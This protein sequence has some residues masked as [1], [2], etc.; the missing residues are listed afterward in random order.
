MNYFL[1]ADNKFVWVLTQ[2]PNQVYCIDL[3][4]PANTKKYPLNFTPGKMVL[5]PANQKLYILN[6]FAYTMGAT[7]LDKIYVM[8]PADG[9]IERTITV[10]LDAYDN[11]QH[12]VVLYNL[13]FGYNGYG[14][15]ETSTIESSSGAPRWRIMD[16]RYND[17]VYVHPAWKGSVGGG[18]LPFA[19]LW[20]SVS[21]YN[22][23]KIYMRRSYSY[24]RGAVMDVNS[25]TMTEM[26]YPSTNPSHYIVPSRKHDKLFIASFQYQTIIGAGSPQYFSPFDNRYSETADFSYRSGDDNVIYYHAREDFPYFDFMILDYNLGKTLM[27]TRVGSDFNNILATTDG[28]YVLAV[29]GGEVVVF[30]VEWFYRWV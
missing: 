3:E 18:N 25:G 1:S 19:L 22:G 29:V 7:N 8:N 15:L 26:I 23:S 9:K 2:D 12:R 5:N 4:N 16:S 24:P 27:K 13:A 28:K 17:T 6:Y 14:I 30:E 11:P 10:P 20:G 21:N